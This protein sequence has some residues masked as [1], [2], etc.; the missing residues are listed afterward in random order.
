V[1]F[2]ILAD[3]E[4][5]DF[6]GGGMETEVEAVVG[7]DAEDMRKGSDPTTPVKAAG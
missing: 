5:R 3:D 1:L 2:E 6:A 4:G 7:A